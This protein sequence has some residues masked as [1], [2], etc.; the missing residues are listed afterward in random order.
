MQVYTGTWA[1]DLEQA[2]MLHSMPQV[3]VNVH[4]L[5]SHRLAAFLD[6]EGKLLPIVH[7]AL[8]KQMGYETA[9]APLPTPAASRRPRIRVANVL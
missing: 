4:H 5:D 3:S 1:H 6:S 2:N 8:A 9:D 7:A